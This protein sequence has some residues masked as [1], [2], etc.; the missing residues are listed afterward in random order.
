MQRLEDFEAF[1][2]IVE[3]GSQTSA[4]KHLGRSLQSINRSLVSLE[5]SV[6][7]ELV[8]RT[9]RLSRSTEAGMV[10]YRRIKA[11]LT[12]ISAAGR[13]VL[14][15]RAEPT[16]LLRVAAPVSFSS[17]F[18]APAIGDFLARYP[19]MNVELKASDRRVDLNREGFDMAVRIRHLPDSNL[20]ARRIAQLR[21]VVYGAPAYFAKQG[22]PRRPEEL[23]LHQC[24]VRT[25]DAG[26][27]RWHFRVGGRRLSMQVNGRFRADDAAT[28]RTA[29]ANAVG[30]GLGPLWQIRELLSQGKVET[31]L[32]EFEAPKIPVMAVSPAAKVPSAKTRLFIDMLAARLRR[33]RL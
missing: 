5:R 27:D 32:E 18:M 25:T 24:V 2:A 13:E 22:R 33:E 8:R 1:V 10:F 4:A 17:A 19:G 29:V 20:R 9:T 7:L 28:I 12:E 30:I 6:G 3:Q 23:A 31:V 14:E 15:L 26:V 11:A 21:I 16:G